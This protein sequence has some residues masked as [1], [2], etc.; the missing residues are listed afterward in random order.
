M[1]GGGGGDCWTQFCKGITQGPFHQSLVQ[2]VPVV[3]EELIKMQKACS[4]KFFCQ[5]IYTDYA[6]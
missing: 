3:L 4:V 6:N 2:I 5:P 1:V